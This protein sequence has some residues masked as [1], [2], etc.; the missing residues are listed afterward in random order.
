MAGSIWFIYKYICINQC[1]IYK[2]KYMF[3]W[4]KQKYHLFNIILWNK[5]KN[6]CMFKCLKDNCILFK[7]SKTTNEYKCFQF[8]KMKCDPCKLSYLFIQFMSVEFRVTTSLNNI[9]SIFGKILTV[10]QFVFGKCNFKKSI[11]SKIKSNVC[12]C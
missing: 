6:K 2:I 7:S 5:F 11:Y 12:I 10:I 1:L 9:S 8:D 4:N 3:K